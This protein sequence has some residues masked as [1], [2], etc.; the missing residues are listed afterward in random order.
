MPDTN[1]PEQQR[2]RLDLSGWLAQEHGRLNNVTD[3]S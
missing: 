3:V 1:S 2:L